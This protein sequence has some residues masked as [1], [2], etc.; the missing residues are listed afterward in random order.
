MIGYDWSYQPDKQ[1]LRRSLI[2]VNPLQQT[3]GV[4][5]IDRDRFKKLQKRFKYDLKEYYQRKD[6]LNKTYSDAYK[7]LTSE[8]FWKQYLEM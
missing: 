1:N 6:Q 8:E 4:R 2:V 7:N 5:T 3:M